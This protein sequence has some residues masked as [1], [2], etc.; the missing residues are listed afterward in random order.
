MKARL[1]TG[2]QI[3]LHSKTYAMDSDVTTQIVFGTI[4][5]ILALL[6]I[7]AAYRNRMGMIVHL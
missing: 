1:S 4:A 7:R 3:K 5:T 2:I 6:G